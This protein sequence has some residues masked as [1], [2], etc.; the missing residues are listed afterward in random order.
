MGH[1]SISRRALKLLIPGFR[2]GF[3]RTVVHHMHQLPSFRPMRVRLYLLCNIVD[4]QISNYYRKY[5]LAGMLWQALP[6]IAPPSRSTRTACRRDRYLDR[7]HP[8][9][10]GS[11]SR[12]AAMMTASHIRSYKWSGL[13]TPL[14]GQKTARVFAAQVASITL[15]HHLFR[16]SPFTKTIVE[17]STRYFAFWLSLIGRCHL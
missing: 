2:P 3:R 15:I 1:L 6:C 10:L 5:T 14:L 13:R 16:F 11:R 7:Q 8:T 17:F 4:G 9:L 12:C